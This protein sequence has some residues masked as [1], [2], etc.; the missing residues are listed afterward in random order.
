MRI[1]GAL[2]A[3]SSLPSTFGIGDLGPKAYEFIDIL[4]KMKLKVWQVLPINPLGYGNSPYQPYSSFAGDEI[5]ISIEKL[6]NDGLI[7]PEEIRPLNQLATKV[8]Y[9]E[10]RSN[11]N[12]M[13]KIAYSR[14]N[15]NKQLVEEFA[16]F[17]KSTS[18]AYEYAVF[19]S[20]KKANNM[21]PW[22][23]WPKEQREWII[24]KKYELTR[25]KSAINF[26]LFIQFIFFR[27]WFELKS[28]ANQHGIQIMGD[29]PIYLGYDSVDVWA[30]QEIFLLDENQNPTF[31]AGVP[32]DY[33]SVTGQRWGNPIYNWDKLIATDFEF[34]IERLRGNMQLFDIIRIDHF[35]AFD[36]Y[37]KIP[38]SCETAVEGEWVEAPGYQLFDMIYKK[39]PDIRIVVE[40][41]G[42][43]RPEVHELRDHY[44]LPGMKIFQFI[45]DSNG[46]NTALDQD[47]NTIIYTGTHDNSTLMGWYWSLRTW[48]RKK[49][50]RYFKANDRNIKYRVL[51]YILN[52]NADNVM[53]PIQDILGLPDEARMNYP[54]TIGSPNWEW[55]LAGFNSLVT[56]IDWLQ[57]QVFASGRG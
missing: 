27:Q 41:L 2:L 26:E 25:F 16:E 20:F 1:S 50:K 48:Q 32:P 33:F 34:W 45:F 51:K 55:K 30:N 21:L 4:A 12:E 5:Y 29:I 37:W 19:V 31:V 7:L 54:S 23:L 53:L 39:L 49:L 57:D 17:I 47:A 44:N 24:D 43:L 42:D 38:A 10:A 22:N 52:C 40:D 56:E 46:K 14:F 18:W 11:K 15:S 13:L 36:T 35:R 9:T 8:N 3:I 28:Y 6:V